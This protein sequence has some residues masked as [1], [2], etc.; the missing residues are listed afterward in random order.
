MTILHH[1][2]AFALISIIFYPYIF[3]LS[4]F[5]YNLIAIY[6]LINYRSTF[7]NFCIHR[8]GIVYHEMISLSLIS[9]LNCVMY[10]CLVLNIF[11]Y[12]R[13]GDDAITI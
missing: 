8:F 5:S 12:I 10:E 7:N 6:T 4:T 13:D 2:Y 9:I 3:Y 1:Q 11:M